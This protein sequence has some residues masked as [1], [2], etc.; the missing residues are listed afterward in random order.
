VANW[1]VRRTL[2]PDMWCAWPAAR[3]IC[4][5]A[6]TAESI[7]V[8]I[9]SSPAATNPLPSE[10]TL[11][12]SHGIAAPAAVTADYAWIDEDHFEL[13]C[14]TLVRGLTL[15]EPSVRPDLRQGYPVLRCGHHRLPE[16]QASRSGGGLMDDKVE[17]TPFGV[18]VYG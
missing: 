18:T 14:L 4:C 12:E 17:V 1:E 10:C 16:A 2:R 7:C 6:V 3:A 15:L 13:C 5:A 9:M 8:A 11:L